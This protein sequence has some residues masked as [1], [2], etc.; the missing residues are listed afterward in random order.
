MRK[1]KKK[2]TDTENS[3]KQRQGTLKNDIFIT[4]TAKKIRKFLTA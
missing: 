3:L 2:K 4:S 1:K